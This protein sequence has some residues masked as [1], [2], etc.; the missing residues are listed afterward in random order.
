[1]LTPKLPAD[2]P[3]IPE[4][5]TDKLGQEIYPG[6]RIVYATAVSSSAYLHVAEVLGFQYSKTTY[7][8]PYLKIKLQK[9]G[10]DKP[11]LI[12]VSGNHYVKVPKENAN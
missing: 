5:I 3:D 7:Y 9:K 8:T 11:S 1:M 6:D 12:N 4:F 10:G 2:I